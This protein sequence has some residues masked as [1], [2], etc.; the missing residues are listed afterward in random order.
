MTD[1]AQPH[2]AAGILLTAPTGRALLMRR[3]PG[4]ADHGSEWAFPGGGIEGDET[5]EQA[6]RREFKEETGHEY[7]GELRAWTRRIHDG[8]DFMTFVGSGEEFTPDLNEEHDLHKWVTLDSALAEPAG[9]VIL[10]PGARVALRRFSMDELEIAQAIR[11]G[12]LVSPQRLGNLFLIAMRVTGTG[13]S[14]RKKLDEF[15]WRDPALYLNDHFLARCSGLEIIWQHPPDELGTKEFREQIVGT[16]FLPFIKGEE[17]WTIARIRDMDAAQLL[18]EEKLSTSP[19]VTFL[20]GDGNRKVSF[21][22]KELLIEGKPSIIDH[23]AICAL[24]VWDKGEAPTGVS[25]LIEQTHTETVTAYKEDSAMPL[26]SGKSKEAFEHNIK[27]EIEAGKPQ[28][29][30]VAIAYSKKRG[31]CEMI[32]SILDDCNAFD[33]RQRGT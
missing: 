11:D 1:A 15:V 4:G 21:E 29:Q 13:A 28:K 17:V 10:H 8:V 19:G 22:D 12:D 9:E 14:Y 7:T 3:R 23:L 26:E 2:R 27:T 31:D 30:A 20:P 33:R 6:A 18:E 32:D 25:N 24:G 16:S 5:A